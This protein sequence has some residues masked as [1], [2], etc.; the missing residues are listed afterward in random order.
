MLPTSLAE[1]DAPVKPCHC[2]FP[3]VATYRFA[4]WQPEPIIVLG[5]APDGELRVVRGDG[6]IGRVAEHRVRLDRAGLA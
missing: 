1:P 6:S 3:C 2:L 5:L 4:D